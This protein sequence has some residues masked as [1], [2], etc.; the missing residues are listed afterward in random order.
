MPGIAQY[1][2]LSV[3]HHTGPL[4]NNSQ[5]T[6]KILGGE[7]KNSTRASYSKKNLVML[8]HCWNY[9]SNCLE[10]TKQRV[11]LNGATPSNLYSLHV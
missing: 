11:C 2:S 1:P 4:R 5:H 6:D 3:S 10:V 7:K 8:E 9:C